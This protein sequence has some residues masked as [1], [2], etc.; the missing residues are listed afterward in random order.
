MSYENLSKR[1]QAELEQLKSAS[2]ESGKMYGMLYMNIEQF[3]IDVDT[4]E[5]VAALKFLVD[6]VLDNVA[7][8]FQFAPIV[9]SI[10][11]EAKSIN[12]REFKL[13]QELIKGITLK[14]RENLIKL[15]KSMKAFNEDGRK[16]EELERDSRVLAQQY[17]QT[18]QQYAKAC[19][20]YGVMPENID[21]IIDDYL[22][23][24]TESSDL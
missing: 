16:L 14:G 9:E 6:E 13:I 10:D 23:N 3:K 7:L 18:S 2:I 8:G 12:Y 17:H 5:K 19:E 20:K 1:K 11:S 22:E 24:S 15:S 21:D 4:D